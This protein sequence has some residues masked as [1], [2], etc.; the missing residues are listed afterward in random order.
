MKIISN[1][2]TVALVVLAG[3]LLA[4]PA[5]AQQTEDHFQ[6]SFAIQSGGTLVVDNYKGLIHVSGS[7]G[8]QVMVNVLK[9]FEGTDKDRTWW[10]ANTHVNFTNVA[11]RVEV[12]VEYPCN[13][14][15]FNWDSHQDYQASVELTIQVP[16]KINLQI[17]GYKPEMN[18]AGIDG[19]IHISSYKAPIEIRSTSGGIHI[20]T[21][22]ETVTLK[23]VAIRGTL[24]LQ[25]QKGEASIEAKNLGERVNL[26]TG[27]GTIVLRAPRNAAMTL[28]YSGGRRSNFSSDFTIAAETGSSSSIRGTINGGGI[29][30]HLRSDKGSITLE[31]M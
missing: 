15:A 27:K 1:K 30:V 2:P 20:E 14:S 9:N 29:Q 19:D 24:D 28:D 11:D 26:E 18:I 10:M 5:S 31:K 22:K 21:Y 12:A 16:R 23:D 6:R 17:K 7:D 4:M 13:C 25:M 3:L 8:N